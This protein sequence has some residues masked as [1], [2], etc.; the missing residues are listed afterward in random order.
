MIPTF[1]TKRLPDGFIHRGGEVT[2][3][4]AFVDAAFAFAM[5]LLVISL[6]SVP[7]DIPAMLA[8][9]KGVPAFAMSFVQ[10]MIFWSAHANW[11]R[12]LGLDDGPS[13]RLSLVLVFL[14]LIYVYPMKILFGAFFAWI[15]HDWLPPVASIHNLDDL[16]AMFVL[17][18]IAFGTLSLCMAALYRQALRSPVTPPLEADEI[19]LVRCEIVRWFYA[20]A[21]AAVSMLFA[22][23]LPDDVPNWL[24]G[25]PGMVYALMALTGALVKRYARRARAAQTVG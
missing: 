16:K 10:I 23:L 2:R 14:M 3:L 8:A 25:M 15:T 11:S 7:S 4:E 6:N 17:Y 12:R 21:L 18:G 13:Q 20:V 1:E 5:T 24:A 22:L 19:V 9:L